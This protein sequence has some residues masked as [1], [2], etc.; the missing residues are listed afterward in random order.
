MVDQVN[1]LSYPLREP[2]RG[3][4]PN[5]QV[6]CGPHRSRSIVGDT[7]DALVLLGLRH[8]LAV[9]GTDNGG[10]EGN[11]VLLRELFFRLVLA[12]SLYFRRG[13]YPFSGGF[14]LLHSFVPRRSFD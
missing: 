12:L 11:L 2:D 4:I 9:V 5:P 13:L 7:R 3:G 8:L 10:L 14:F 6:P 1:F